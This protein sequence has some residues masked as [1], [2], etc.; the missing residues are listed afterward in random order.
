MHPSSHSRYKYKER[1]HF[2]D[3]IDEYHH[4]YS[5]DK[6]PFSPPRPVSNFKQRTLK[7]N[8][9]N[10]QIR[11]HYTHTP[12]SCPFDQHRT[13]STYMEKVK[14]LQSLKRRNQLTWNPAYDA[15]PE[16]LEQLDQLQPPVI[17][18]VPINTTH[19]IK[20]S[21]QS[22]IPSSS[23]LSTH[24]KHVQ[25][26]RSNNTTSSTMQSN[27]TSYLSSLTFSKDQETFIHDSIEH[28]LTRHM[29]KL[30]K[31]VVLTSERIT[32]QQQTHFTSLLD[33]H[34]RDLRILLSQPD[35]SGLIKE[36]KHMMQENRQTWHNVSSLIQSLM[37]H[38]KM[39]AIEQPHVQDIN[40]NRHDMLTES[41]LVDLLH[42]HHE[43][44]VQNIEKYRHDRQEITDQEVHPSNPRRLEIQQSLQHLFHQH[45]DKMV[46]QQQKQSTLLLEQLTSCLSM[47]YQQQ[48][49]EIMHT[50][51]QIQQQTLSSQNT[52]ETIA[53][54]LPQIYNVIK[55]QLCVNSPSSSSSIDMPSSFDPSS[56]SNSI[57]VP[58]SLDSSSSLSLP[59]IPSLDTSSLLSLPSN[60]SLVPSSHTSPPTLI[61]MI[62][63]IMNQIHV[64]NERNIDSISS[65]TLSSSAASSSSFLFEQ[66]MCQLKSLSSDIDQIKHM[67]DTLTTLTEN[68]QMVA[69]QLQELAAVIHADHHTVEIEP[70]TKNHDN[71]DEQSCHLNAMD[72]IENQPFEINHHI[73][74]SIEQLLN[75][76]TTMQALMQMDVKP[77]LMEVKT[78]MDH[79][80]HLQS[81]VSMVSEK[82]THHL[83]K[84]A[85]ASSSSS[86]S[87]L[88]SES[89]ISPLISSENNNIENVMCVDWMDQ[90]LSHIRTSMAMLVETATGHFE[91]HH[92][93]LDQQI[94]NLS[95]QFGVFSDQW[96]QT[97]NLH[98]HD[99]SD[100]KTF[101]HTT[102]ATLDI[103]RLKMETMQQSMVDMCDT[104]DST[105]DSSM[106]NVIHVNDQALINHPPWESLEQIIQTDIASK[107]NV[108]LNHYHG[109]EQ[110]LIQLN[111]S[112]QNVTSQVAS[113]QDIDQWCDQVHKTYDQLKKSML[114]HYQDIGHRMDQ[115]VQ[116]QHDHVALLVNNIYDKLNVDFKQHF[117]LLSQSIS[118]SHAQLD[119]A[120]KSTEEKTNQ[121]YIAQS[122]LMSTMIKDISNQSQHQ[123]EQT[124]QMIKLYLTTID[125]KMSTFTQHLDQ[126][127]CI[128]KEQKYHQ[129]HTNTS[130]P[131]SISST[132]ADDQSLKRGDGMN[133]KN[134][135]DIPSRHRRQLRCW[136]D[137]LLSNHRSNPSHHDQ[138]HV[139]IINH[140]L[141]HDHDHDHDHDPHHLR[142]SYSSEPTINSINTPHLLKHSNDAHDNESDSDTSD[143][144]SVME[145][146]QMII[147]M[148]RRVMKLMPKKTVHV[149]DTDNSDTDNDSSDYDSDDDDVVSISSSGSFYASSSRSSESDR[150]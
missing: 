13:E 49:S 101:I 122:K 128:N 17:D 1:G 20:Q 71:N 138:R 21:Q 79:Y 2:H 142:S 145:S 124:E 100:I 112:L 61:T 83:K 109:V 41:K 82:L 36:F 40:D 31:L 47:Q 106:N 30:M 6:H 139:V 119:Q 9:H 133:R 146:P 123:F 78:M 93:H 10:H 50:Q 126:Q 140:K 74:S 94:S 148:V 69:L 57:D 98:Q 88:T 91:N 48:R 33:Q 68:M 37:D 73:T 22:H 144:E 44:I 147:K 134:L 125:E 18:I 45:M 15:H 97:Q 54:L 63:T 28:G 96:I 26:L 131:S 19:D 65:N 51:Q 102:Q 130:S 3:N 118:N 107:I 32:Q 111:E 149:S 25:S 103:L 89:S 116:Q 12:S 110:T 24:S 120:F 27:T 86:S 104:R 121:Q 35:Q 137:R 39:A 92:Q 99:P 115:H 16:W 70:S 150:S 62:N 80:S 127:K 77:M 87:L 23:E 90:Q 29:D 76:S 53:H 136:D 66:C 135:H 56:L 43:T 141:N 67:D 42:V 75:H 8:N 143:C 114:D 64:M 14:R 105:L 58:S 11:Q 4:A 95:Q 38:P 85:S 60:P 84:N 59:S 81:N 52:L 132:Y 55:T 108:L 72:K 7:D 5:H 34:H 113:K 129:D 117:D 46:E